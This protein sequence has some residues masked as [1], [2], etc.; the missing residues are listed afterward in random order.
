MTIRRV[1]VKHLRAISILLAFDV[2]RRQS[3][4]RHTLELPLRKWA[5]FEPDPF[6]AEACLRQGLRQILGK[7]DELG[8]SADSSGLIDYADGPLFH[9]NIQSGTMF[10]E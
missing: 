8:F 1:W 10:Y 6:D 9:Q 4:A 7:A 3:S 5:S 2:G